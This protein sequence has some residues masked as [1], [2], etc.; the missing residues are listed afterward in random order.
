MGSE[1]FGKCDLLI[2]MGTSLKVHPFAGLI[3][4]VND[5]CPRLLINMEAVATWTLNDPERD[6]FLKG[7]CDD[8]VRELAK[9]LGWGKELEQL[10]ED[11]KGNVE[12]NKSVGAIS[13]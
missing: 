12:R 10:R 9:I 2:I 4:R 8:G 3:T 6:F 11:L 7:T 13:N 1:D 5:N